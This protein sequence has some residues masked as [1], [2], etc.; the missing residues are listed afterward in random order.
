MELTQITDAPMREEEIDY[1]TIEVMPDDEGDQPVQ[2]LS[3]EDKYMFRQMH[4]QRNTFT[5]KGIVISS[6]FDSGNLAAC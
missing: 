1:A 6:D 3:N 5:F 2:Y 4:P